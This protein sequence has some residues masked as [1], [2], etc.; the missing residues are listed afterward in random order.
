MAFSSGPGG[1]RY[2]AGKRV[3]CQ[4]TTCQRPS[5]CTSTSVNRK[6]KLLF[7][8]FTAAFPVTTA[9]SP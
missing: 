4:A 2:R 9:V 1:N 3:D 8:V 7:D 6:E 5:R